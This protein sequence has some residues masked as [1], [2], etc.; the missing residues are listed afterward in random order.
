MAA[1]SLFWACKIREKGIVNNSS[2]NGYNSKQDNDNN[3]S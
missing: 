3:I 2:N 1:K